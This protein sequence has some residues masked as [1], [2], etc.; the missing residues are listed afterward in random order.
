WERGCVLRFIEQM[1][2]PGADFIPVPGDEIRAQLAAA[3][4]AL[5][6]E[7]PDGGIAVWYRSGGQRLGFI[8]AHRHDSCQTCSR[9]R[10]SFDGRLRPCLY[11]PEEIDLKPALR[12][13]ADLRPLLLAAVARKPRQ[14]VTAADAVLVRPMLK[15]GG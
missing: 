14:G 11:S 6:P 2:V 3:G 4:L 12:A 7:P 15:T 10:L 13:G 9:L 8:S 1:P 5:A